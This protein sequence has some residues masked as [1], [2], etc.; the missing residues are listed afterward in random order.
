LPNGKIVGYCSLAILI[1]LYVVGAVSAIPGSLRHEV[2]TL[3]LW[4]PIVGGFQ[5]KEWAKWAALPCMIFWLTIMIF[6]WL[7]LLGWA[8]VVSGTFNP[9][10]IAMTLV[11]GAA[12]VAGIVVGL[13]W[14]TA[15]RAM[16]AVGVFLL[17]ATL[18][19]AAMAISLTPYIARR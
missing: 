1:A 3:P 7:F 15:T 18:Q 2:Q 5:K 14:R 12:S 11:V 10:E 8:R 4:F 16:P 13:R 6:I 9:I 17:F 19:V